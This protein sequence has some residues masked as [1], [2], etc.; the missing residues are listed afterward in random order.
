MQLVEGGSLS[1]KSDNKTK[2]TLYISALQ[3]S[4]EYLLFPLMCNSGISLFLFKQS[5]ITY[6]A[7][8]TKEVA[9]E[10][11]TKSIYLFFFCPYDFDRIGE[12]PYCSSV[13]VTLTEDNC[14]GLAEVC[15]HF[16]ATHGTT[17]S[18]FLWHPDG[19]DV[20][21]GPSVPS[22]RASAGSASPPACTMFRVARVATR[23]CLSS[24]QQAVIVIGKFDAFAICAVH[25]R[26]N[27]KL[28]NQCSPSGV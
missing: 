12:S 25:Y 8:R 4:N 22:K 26:D 17:G 3:H 5:Y 2:R 19:D 9:E 23:R 20:D 13:E 14:S 16:K 1:F 6:S 24:A 10:H 27:K 7:Q 18:D 15:V 11:D 21:P 28:F